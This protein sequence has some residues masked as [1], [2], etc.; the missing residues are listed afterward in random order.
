MGTSKRETTCFQSL[1]IA[2]LLTLQDIFFEQDNGLVDLD[3]LFQMGRPAIGE[4]GQE[5][6]CKQARSQ[7]VASLLPHPCI[8]SLSP[9]WTLNL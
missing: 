2:P 5:I 8:F 4:K 1:K 9:T 6:Q 3:S 7:C